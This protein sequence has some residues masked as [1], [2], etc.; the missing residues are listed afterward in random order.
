MTCERCGR[1]PANGIQAPVAERECAEVAAAFERGKE[2][3]RDIVAR[4][5]R[6]RERAAAPNSLVVLESLIRALKPGG[7]VRGAGASSAPAIGLARN[8]VTSIL[9]AVDEKIRSGR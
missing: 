9:D 4:E 1:R 5:R 7:G 6:A 3:A 2:A 8:I